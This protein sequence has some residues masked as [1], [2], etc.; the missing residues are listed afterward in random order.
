MDTML[1]NLKN[2]V[3]HGP[4]TFGFLES[5]S[6]VDACAVLTQVEAS[7]WE[8]NVD[9]CQR[10]IELFIYTSAIKLAIV[11]MLAVIAFYATLEI[12]S[13]CKSTTTI[14]VQLQAPEQAAEQKQLTATKN[15][16][17]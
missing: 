5:T 9:E 10:R 8:R 16:S 14:H 4:S 17:G 6:D 12:I 13:R 1:L 2:I 3:V 7:F 15:K 11:M